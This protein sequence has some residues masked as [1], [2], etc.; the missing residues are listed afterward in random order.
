MAIDQLTPEQVSGAALSAAHGP[1]FVRVN[2]MIAQINAN[3]AAIGG[4]TNPLLFKGEIN[5]AADFPDPGDVQNGWTYAVKTD[6]TD[7]DPT[8]TNTGQSFQ[9]GDEIA[10]NGTNWTVLGALIFAPDM[11]KFVARNGDDTNG[12]GSPQKPFK[13]VQAGYDAVAA[14]G[15]T[16]ANPGAVYVYPGE[17]QETVIADEDNVAI[18]GVGGQQVTNIGFDAEPSLII[19]NATRAS[20]AAFLAAGGGVDPAANFATLVAG[21]KTPRNV[22]VRGIS[23]HP[24]NG[25]T[26][27]RLIA[28]G[29]G[30]GNTV[31]GS[32]INF[33]GCCNWGKTWARGVNYVSIQGG[34]WFAK[35]IEAHNVAGVWAND[36]QIAGYAG[37]YNVADDEPS[38]AGNY[39]LCGGKTLNNGGI[40]LTGS[41]RAGAGDPNGGLVLLQVTGD[42]DLDGTSALVMAS[43]GIGGDIDTEAGA[44]FEMRN[45]HVQGGV[46]IAAGAGTAQMDGGA[47]MGALV[48]PG[49][50][51]VRNLGS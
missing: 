16:Q 49:A 37:Y 46:T 14:M 17:Y 48:D 10:W 22:Q 34:S 51:L 6:V 21:A 25:G 44:S 39:G 31:G 38:D 32:E 26:A 1:A 40:A 18:I 41:A 13:T 43:S 2:Q 20:V 24:T 28:A 15:P 35:L 12:D 27:Y 30:A 33:M 11:V 45:V 7:N 29:I 23:M 47:Y 19:T 36:V 8:R 9:A 4:L 3:E 50:K 42:L 5:A